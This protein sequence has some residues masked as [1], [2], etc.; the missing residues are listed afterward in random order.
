MALGDR[1]WI[2]RTMGFT[3]IIGRFIVV[4]VYAGDVSGNSYGESLGL[5]YA[6]EW[7]AGSGRYGGG[8]GCIG[9][10]AGRSDAEK[11]DSGKAVDRLTH[12]CIGCIRMHRFQVSWQT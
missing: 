5:F 6:A 4:Y 10:Y 12:Y 11:S 9:N 1:A 3:D 8:F 7:C 2:F